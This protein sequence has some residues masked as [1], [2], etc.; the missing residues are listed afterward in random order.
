VL[1]TS[2]SVILLFQSCNGRN[3]GCH[4]HQLCSR[5]TPV[6]LPALRHHGPA[7]PSREQSGPHC[8]FKCC[9]G[10][11]P[12]RVGNFAPRYFG[13]WRTGLGSASPSL[14]QPAFAA[15]PRGAGYCTRHHRLQPQLLLLQSRSRQ[16]S[17]DTLRNVYH[18]RYGTE[19]QRHYRPNA[20]YPVGSDRSVGTGSNPV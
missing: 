16:C 2:K 4:A 10:L 6:R 17:S 15:C 11:Q 19:Q 12:G 13:S 7:D 3:F 9:E 18:H 1:G 20:K 14:A 8:R 5:L